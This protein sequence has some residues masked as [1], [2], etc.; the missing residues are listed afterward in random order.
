MRLLA[1]LILARWSSLEYAA[2][3]PQSQIGWLGVCQA[4]KCFRERNV[5]DAYYMRDALSV[6]FYIP[7]KNESKKRG[8][9]WRRKCSACP[10]RNKQIDSLKF[11]AIY[12][13]QGTHNYN[14]YYER[15][16]WYATASAA[17]IGDAIRRNAS[18]VATVTDWERD[19]WQDFIGNALKSI[20]VTTVQYDRS[21]L[22]SL[23]LDNTRAWMTHNAHSNA[24][25][26][27]DP[28]DST[29]NTCTA[30]FRSIVLHQLGLDAAPPLSS[31]LV[32]VVLRTQLSAQAQW[33][34]GLYGGYSIPRAILNDAGTQ[35]D[36]SLL[37]YVKSAF[38][39]DV[40]VPYFGNESL[41]DTVSVF[42]R[43]C[44]VLGIHG[45][46]FSNVIFSRRNTLAIEITL[47]R[48]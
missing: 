8:L 14:G 26:A 15:L 45:A 35:Y 27:R 38:G 13:I 10:P 28:K 11:D 6:L 21:T 36:Y 9:Y 12:D 20:G 19:P 39:G 30:C 1:V 25:G 40:V 41:R 46:G 48:A 7:P 24:A 34:A 5:V 22:P 43:A 47:H 32:V 2:S 42:S 31:C 29:L 17:F 4:S 37:E 44:V 23:G 33:I 16:A 18:T 3:I